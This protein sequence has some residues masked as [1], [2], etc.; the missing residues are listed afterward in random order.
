N[1]LTPDNTP[2]EQ[3]GQLI[4]AVSAIAQRIDVPCYDPT[5]LMNK[6]GQADAMENGGL[7][8][9]HYTPVFAE[10][11]CTEWFKTYMRPKMDTSTSQ[12]AVPKL[13]ADD[14]AES[15]EK[16]WDA[17]DLRAASRRVR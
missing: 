10:R 12:P 14:S 7:D 3:R 2:I 6:I 15:I 13:G 11:L 1:A 5:P 9:T 8:L 16:A 4:A 17:G